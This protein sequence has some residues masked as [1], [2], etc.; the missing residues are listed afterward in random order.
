[1]NIAM[2]LFEMSS[3]QVVTMRHGRQGA[4][5]HFSPRETPLPITPLT[6]IVGYSC[7]SPR[8][9][10]RTPD[11]SQPGPA[12]PSPIPVLKVMPMLSWC[13]CWSR[14]QCQTRPL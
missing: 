5:F 13:Q 14:Y 3:A 12:Q 11:P 10:W 8:S 6:G 9:R 1:M 4:S 2:H 7:F